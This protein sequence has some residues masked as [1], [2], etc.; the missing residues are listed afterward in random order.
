MPQPAP[1]GRHTDSLR[2]AFPQR[3]GGAGV[4]ALELRGEQPQLLERAS[5]ITCSGFRSSG[6]R[7]DQL[8]AQTPPRRGFSP[9]VLHPRGLATAPLVGGRGSSSWDRPAGRWSAAAAPP[10]AGPRFLGAGGSRPW[11]V[12]SRPTR[13]GRPAPPRRGGR[14]NS[15]AGRRRRSGRGTRQPAKLR[16]SA[17][18]HLAGVG[19]RDE[20]VALVHLARPPVTHPLQQA[21]EAGVDASVPA[22]HKAHPVAAG[23]QL[24]AL[25][26]AA[27]GLL[28]CFSE[29]FRPRG[30]ELD[31]QNPLHTDRP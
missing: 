1:V 7:R 6:S 27:A 20:L 28:D 23:P 9:I 11:S 24:A 25:A 3:A 5:V 19:G 14:G 13:P 16:R 18:A 2:H 10:S 8:A 15:A 17:P 12:C 26:G 22:Q 29:S 21:G 31:R 30:A 4:A